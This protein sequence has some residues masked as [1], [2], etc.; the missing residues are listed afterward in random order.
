ME[1]VAV[2]KASTSTLG[3][4]GIFGVCSGAGRTSTL[5]HGPFGRAAVDE[6]PANLEVDPANMDLLVHLK[7][8]PE[9][10][11]VSAQEAPVNGDPL[12]QPSRI[13]DRRPHARGRD[14]DFSRCS[15]DAHVLLAVSPG[16]ELARRMTAPRGD[17]RVRISAL[18]AART[19]PT[20]P[21]PVPRQSQRSVISRATTPARG[22]RQAAD[23]HAGWP[24]GGARARVARR[25]WPPRG[26]L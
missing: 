2:V 5:P 15:D 20:P 14:G 10:R 6:R 21:A 16:R 24:S 7:A 25:R 22:H 12:L 13:H 19:L 26:A 8:H 9:W 11:V 23:L 17:V 1:L 18:P 3:L 4:Q